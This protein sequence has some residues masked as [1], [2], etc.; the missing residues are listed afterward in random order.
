M[1]K[2]HLQL[3]FFS[4]MTLFS[5]NFI[6]SLSEGR[7]VRVK[8]THAR[9]ACVFFT[10]ANLDCHMQPFIM[11]VALLEHPQWAVMVCDCDQK[12]L[13]CT[14]FLVLYPVAH[15]ATRHDVGF[16]FNHYL[17][18]F[19]VRFLQYSDSRWSLAKRAY[20]QPV[21]FLSITHVFF[22]CLEIPKLITYCETRYKKLSKN[23]FYA[24]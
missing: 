1:Q 18:K 19:L 4:E 14:L 10:H 11:Q 12:L 20:G 22:K 23:N 9:L 6:F 8:N 3:L 2:A 7:G 5:C 24:C 15:I 21:Q 16:P 17:P 13:S